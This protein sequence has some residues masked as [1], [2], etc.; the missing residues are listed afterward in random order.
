MRQDHLVTA[1]AWRHQIVVRQHSCLT[2][3]DKSAHTFLLQTVV[4]TMASSYIIL[5]VVHEDVVD[6]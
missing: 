1:K 4:I 3:S 2:Q 5:Y 6:P